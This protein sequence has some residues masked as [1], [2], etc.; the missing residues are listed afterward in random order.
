MKKMVE[1]LLDTSFILACIEN[2]VDFFEDLENEGY[3]ILI[4]KG[5][6]NELRGLKKELAL[7]ILENNNFKE[8]ELNGKIVDY[9]IINYAKENPNIIIATLDNGMKSKMKNKKMIIRN[10]K[11]LEID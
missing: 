3:E 7:K 10:R 5:V 6:I 8:I 9:S 1:I 2:K 11:K 4:P